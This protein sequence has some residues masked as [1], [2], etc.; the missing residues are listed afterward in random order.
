MIKALLVL[1]VL[2]CSLYI[3]LVPEEQA[4]C[5]MTYMRPS[6]ALK[7]AQGRYKLWAYREADAKYPNVRSI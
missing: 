3:K 4:Q 2:C 6:Y 5:R 1:A 7:D